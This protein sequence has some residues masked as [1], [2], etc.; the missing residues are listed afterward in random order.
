M[1]CFVSN[2]PKAFWQSVSYCDYD[3]ELYNTTYSVNSGFFT[4][5]L[6]K[7]LEITELTM[8][9]ALY[10][11]QSKGKKQDSVRLIQQ[12]GLLMMYKCRVIQH[13]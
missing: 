7:A 13:H 1:F 10:Q 2:I 9:A 11:F 6:F 12:M 5:V 4:K 3:H 8:K